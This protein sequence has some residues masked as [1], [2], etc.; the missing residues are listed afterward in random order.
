M[1]GRIVISLIILVVYMAIIM[2]APK[3]QLGSGDRSLTEMVSEQISYGLVVALFFL[4]GVV[5]FFGWRRDVGLNPLRSS[6]SLLILWLPILFI[7]AFFAVGLAVGLPTIQVLFFIGTNTL[8]VGITEE[9]AFRGILFSGARSAFRPIGAIAF[10]S[11]IFG[12]V[13]ALNGFETGDWF[14]AGVQAIAAG[15]SG[16]LFIAILIRTGSIIPAMI[17]HWLW[18]LSVFTVGAGAHHE[19]APVAGPA[20][21]TTIVVPVLIAMPNF[22]YALWLLR[23]V[24]A[25]SNEELIA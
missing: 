23:G 25:K 9:L 12:A 17:I 22:I 16:L 6:T 13:H 20:S 15:M 5:A 21:L 14:A 2:V 7:L 3:I 19:V 1:K 24:G 10:T 18:D 8:M 4:S 11:A